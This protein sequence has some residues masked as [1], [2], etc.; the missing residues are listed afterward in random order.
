MVSPY[1]RDVKIYS[2]IK[3]EEL[4]QYFPV[5]D[6]REEQTRKLIEAEAEMIRTAMAKGVPVA[7][8]SP[9]GSGKTAM[10]V[11]LATYLARHG[12]RVLYITK[13]EANRLELTMRFASTMKRM[14]DRGEEPPPVL[15]LFNRMRTCP[16][17]E[18][19]RAV[20]EEIKKSGKMLSPHEREG[21]QYLLFYAKCRELIESGRCPFYNNAQRVKN[22]LPGIDLKPM[23][24]SIKADKQIS[25]VYKYI[26]QYGSLDKVD[27]IMDF[28]ELSNH[29]EITRHTGGGGVCVFELIPELV[30]RF[31]VV[32]VDHWHIAIMG[33]MRWL[34][35]ISSSSWIIAD[36]FH[37]IPSI[38]AVTARVETIK[39]M[40]RKLG[41]REEAEELEKRWAEYRGELVRSILN[42]ERRRTEYERYGAASTEINRS[43]LELIFTR[44]LIEKMASRIKERGGGTR[45]RVILEKLRAIVYGD[46]VEPFYV[47]TGEGE[48][49]IV[50]V[51]HI[52]LLYSEKPVLLL[53]ATASKYDIWN[54]A[55]ANVRFRD[56]DKYI[57]VIESR[58]PRTTYVI[59]VD[60]R[61]EN[62]ES[63]AGLIRWIE[64]RSPTLRERR[65]ATK[66]IIAPQSWRE[67]L[68]KH[69]PIYTPPPISGLSPQT[70]VEIV[71]EILEKARQGYWIHLSP[72]S[73]LAV[74]LD[75]V[76]PS[77]EHHTVAVV[78]SE[79]TPKTNVVSSA[80]L[81]YYMKHY[82]GGDPDK[83][84]R[85]A[86]YVLMI[87]KG[88]MRV[89]QALGRFQ[90][91]P[92]HKL[93]VWFVGR[94]FANVVEGKVVG[95][96]LSWYKYQELY[97]EIKPAH[98][99]TV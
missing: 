12:E 19:H 59:P 17:E 89:L 15:V 29:P 74:G 95:G 79:S 32:V 76:D 87:R 97:G 22:I 7:I 72:H 52:A 41:L 10:N 66:V 75:I 94:H 58:F 8:I 47:M 96:L 55:R 2:G 50:G 45:Y 88:V 93:E 33:L 57:R 26:H 25:P 43:R 30:N 23:L 35:D 54:V 4:S 31:R 83:D 91:S 99:Y 13:G 86:V 20:D 69:V 14:M 24:V 40:A 90:R 63:V 1:L 92:L 38:L 5:E 46:R 51:L 80:I 44:E 71:K 6:T 67:I 3:H 37:D 73:G 21:L 48:D 49:Y 98:T 36:E 70:K 84:Y 78:L 28:K 27:F 34:R 9:T 61:Y 18:V 56:L 53:S 11:A 42:D 85:R 16:N 77:K 62:R 68:E 60:A 39:R 82:G 81:E 65:D 64:E